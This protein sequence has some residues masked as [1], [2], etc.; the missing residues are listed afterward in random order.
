MFT[1]KAFLFA[2]LVAVASA[3][4]PIARGMFFHVEY[5]KIDENNHFAKKLTFVSCLP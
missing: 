3:F 4:A 1:I 2:A 5:A